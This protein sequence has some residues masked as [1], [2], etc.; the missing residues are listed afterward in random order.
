M[1]IPMSTEASENK[2]IDSTDINIA[3][4][5]TDS[6]HVVQ[7]TEGHCEIFTQSELDQTP[8]NL[9]TWGPFTSRNAA[10]AK[11]VGLIRAG[12]CMPK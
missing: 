6:W 11:R 12:K 2:N 3:S 9:D 8:D 7:Q 1:L 10:I 5:E 4:V